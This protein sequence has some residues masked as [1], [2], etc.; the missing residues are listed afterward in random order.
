M[1]NRKVSYILDQVM[2]LTGFVGMIILITL[3]GVAILRNILTI[4]N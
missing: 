1:V 2:F 3:A 4:F